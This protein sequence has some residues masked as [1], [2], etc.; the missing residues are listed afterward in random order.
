M[1]DSKACA[2]AS[3]ACIEPVITARSAVSV[4]NTAVTAFD[5]PHQGSVRCNRRLQQYN[6]SAVSSNDFGQQARLLQVQVFGLQN[7][8]KMKLVRL[9]SC[10]NTR[11]STVQRQDHLQRLTHTCEFVSPQAFAGISPARPAR[12]LQLWS[13]AS[14][15]FHVHG[16]RSPSCCMEAP[17]GEALV[18]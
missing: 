3:R 9:N 4:V 16:P 8:P 18:I 10:W 17:I 2:F 11:F 5:T 12:C 6:T 7:S 13:I 14:V 1:R 15:C